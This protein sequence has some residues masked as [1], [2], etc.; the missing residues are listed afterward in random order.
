MKKAAWLSILLLAGCAGLADQ[1]PRGRFFHVRIDGFSGVVVQVTA[2]S[3]PA[4]ATLAEV[5]AASSSRELVMHFQ[6]LPMCN[7]IISELERRRAAMVLR[8]SC[9]LGQ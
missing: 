9:R 4:V 5:P 7:F 1:Q 2:A 3:L 6:T 8:S